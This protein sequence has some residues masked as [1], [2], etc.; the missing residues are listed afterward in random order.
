MAGSIFRKAKRF[1]IQHYGRSRRA[2]I[3]RQE[4]LAEEKKTTKSSPKISLPK[5]DTI[6]RKI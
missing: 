6:K 5:K 3:R 2:E 1:G 4:Q